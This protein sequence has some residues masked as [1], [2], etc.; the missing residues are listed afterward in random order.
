MGSTR[1]PREALR[2]AAMLAASVMPD[3]NAPIAIRAAGGRLTVS[4]SGPSAG[5][6][7]YI[8]CDSS[9]SFSAAVHQRSLT[10]ALGGSEDTV[11]ISIGRKHLEIA[12]GASY[13]IPLADSGA[14][15]FDPPIPSDFFT[16]GADALK[17]AL[18]CAM[19]FETK[20]TPP[21]MN[22]VAFSLEDGSAIVY[23]LRSSSGI[24]IE[25]GKLEGFVPFTIPHWGARIVS[26][27]A[28]GQLAKVHVA[29]TCAVFVFD[30]SVVSIGRCS[31][32]FISCP[33]TPFVFSGGEPTNIPADEFIGFAKRAA[34][35]D[36]DRV[37]ISDCG[38][39]IAKLDA[40]SQIASI[41]AQID[42]TGT[43]PGN[44]TLSPDNIA[45]LGLLG[46]DVLRMF[47]HEDPVRKFSVPGKTLAIAEME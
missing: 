17:G 35:I 7:S 32:Q 31:S 8:A 47:G 33:W 36:A 38:N 5:I 11:G 15:P 45:K 14:E 27:A 23:G 44:V 19:A 39:G 26:R 4:G 41:S 37:M 29:E 46:A 13:K 24:R 1:I 12:A 9:E 25:L 18:E 21:G 16:I 40:V 43:G 22:A 6:A 10:V 3:E 28:S 30:S 34:A 20:G 42:Y 2:A